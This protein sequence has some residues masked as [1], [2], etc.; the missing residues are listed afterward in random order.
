MYFYG[1]RWYDDVVQ[2]FLSADTIVP[3]AGNSQALMV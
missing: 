2:R 3:G 1:A